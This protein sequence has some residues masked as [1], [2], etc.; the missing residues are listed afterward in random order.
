MVQRQNGCIQTSAFSPPFTQLHISFHLRYASWDL[1][2][3]RLLKTAS[4]DTPD[5]YL[6]KLCTAIQSLD[7]LV[8]NTV[9]VHY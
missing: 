1:L 7:S 4:M 2:C 3:M 6:H 9:V 8:H 5:G